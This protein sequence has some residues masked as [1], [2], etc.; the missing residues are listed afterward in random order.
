MVKEY[1]EDNTI[2]FRITEDQAR[3]LCNYYREDIDELEEYEIAS[4]LDR[5]IDE[6]L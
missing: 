6:N 2:L 3:S 4:L 1:M 5:F